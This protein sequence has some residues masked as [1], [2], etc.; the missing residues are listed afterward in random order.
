MRLFSKKQD[1]GDDNVDL[2]N[3]H[4][5]WAGSDDAAPPPPPFDPA[6]ATAVSPTPPADDSGWFM[7][8]LDMAG[9]TPAPDAFDGLP[10]IDQIAL[11]PLPSD[12]PLGELTRQALDPA[13]PAIPSF[14]TAGFG[15]AAPTAPSA[16][17]FA[18]APTV[19]TPGAPPTAPGTFPSV[20][21][22]SA[23]TP[24]APVGSPLSAPAMDLP[25]M[26]SPSAPTGGA[27]IDTPFAPAAPAANT[28]TAVDAPSVGGPVGDAAGPLLAVL[29][30]TPGA[31]WQDVVTAHRAIVLQFDR[32]PADHRVRE[33]NQ[34]FSGL[35]LLA[36]A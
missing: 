3:D 33:A 27:P 11:D 4:E 6:V 23:P 2:Q 5:W 21:A 32:D 24:S 20:P 1:T 36:V 22:P 14:D 31:T 12:N 18:A 19:P 17:P 9:S 34:A 15:G 13:Q 7:P 26:S 35:R 10:P 28:P 25:P 16:D 8:D 30:L 29:G